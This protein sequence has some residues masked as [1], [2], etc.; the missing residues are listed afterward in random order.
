M[1]VEDARLGASLNAFIAQYGTPASKDKGEDIWRNGLSATQEYP[2][3]PHVSSIMMSKPDNTLYT[4]QAGKAACIGFLPQDASDLH[5]HL[6][7][8]NSDGSLYEEE[9][10]YHSASIAKLFPASLFTDQNN[11]PATVGT[12]ALTLVYYGTSGFV[13]CGVQIGMY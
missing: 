2:D 4:M 6:T 9:Y 12:T 3:I 11:N 5:K 1:P 13:E 7:R 10:V 8:Y